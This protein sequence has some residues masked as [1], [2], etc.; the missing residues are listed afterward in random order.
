[1]FHARVQNGRALVGSLELAC[2]E[3]PQREARAATL[4]VRPH[5][6][7]IERSPNGGGSLRARIDR[8]NAAGPVAKVFLSALES[9][10]QLNVEVSAQ[11][12]DELALQTGDTVWVAPRKV[13]V[14]APEYVI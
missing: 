8:I 5:E 3:Y 12:Y 2:P 1:V 13:R 14:F 4:Y 11:R 9:D 6:L 7:D 10:V